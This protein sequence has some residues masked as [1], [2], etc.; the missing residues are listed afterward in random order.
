MEDHEAQEL[1]DD[2]VSATSDERRKEREEEQ[3][4][5]QQQQ[6]QPRKAADPKRFARDDASGGL[7]SHSGCCRDQPIPKDDII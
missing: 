7:T 3:Q 1:L 4:Q 5:Q 2:I 6:R